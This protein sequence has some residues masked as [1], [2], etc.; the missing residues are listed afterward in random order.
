RATGVHPTVSTTVS[1]IGGTAARSLFGDMGT[2]SPS[3]DRTHR[4]RRTVGRGRRRMRRVRGAREPF[5]DAPLSLRPHDRGQVLGCVLSPTR[6]GA[7]PCGTPLV[8]PRSYP[9]DAAASTDAGR[10]LP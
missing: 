5:V 4:A 9:L 10:I 8:T 6:A 1:T 7:W 3:P 2:S